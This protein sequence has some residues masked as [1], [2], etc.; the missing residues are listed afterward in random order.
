[1]SP[2]VTVRF[3]SL[4]VLDKWDA[5]SQSIKSPESSSSASR[6]SNNIFTR[7]RG[8]LSFHFLIAQILI[9]PITRRAS[10][11][12]P[13]SHFCSNHQCSTDAGL[14]FRIFAARGPS[15]ASDAPASFGASTRSDLV[16]AC[17]SQ[18]SSSILSCPGELP[19][20]FSFVP[21]S[22]VCVDDVPV[23]D[24]RL[25]G[26][27]IDVSFSCSAVFILR[28]L[29]TLAVHLQVQFF[30]LQSLTVP[31]SSYEVLETRICSIRGWKTGRVGVA[32]S[33]VDMHR[34]RCAIEL[35]WE[36]PSPGVPTVRPLSV[37]AYRRDKAIRRRDRTR[38]PV[39]TPQL[40][41]PLES[42]KQ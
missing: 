22:H 39:T 33:T 4:S 12:A 7:D 19:L 41:T 35:R 31:N 8:V 11:V 29:V 20:K 14:R 21:W 28:A 5:L 3:S 17:K 16:S 26:A 13:C 25:V 38:Q 15:V 37:H 34:V 30:N 32:R 2:N 24:D 42:V 6:R 1:M 27:L 18:T 40:V 36:R 23:S 9:E 10:S